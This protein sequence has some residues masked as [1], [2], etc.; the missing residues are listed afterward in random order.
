MITP[1]WILSEEVA[2]PYEEGQPLIGVISIIT[3][4]SIFSLS[5]A[6]LTHLDNFSKVLPFEAW[7]N[8]IDFEKVSIWK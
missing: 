4:Y 1:F 3:F 2:S 5:N 8:E 6:A 7:W